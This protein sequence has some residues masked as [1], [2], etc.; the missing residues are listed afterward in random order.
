MAS[1]MIT[2]DTG[3]NTQ[4]KRKRV[5]TVYDV[6]PVMAPEGYV[7][8]FAE[9]LESADQLKNSLEDHYRS[10]SVTLNLDWDEM[11]PDRHISVSFI[12]KPDYLFDFAVTARDV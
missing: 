9:T 1:Q 7:S 11:E 5:K 10:H 2:E 12:C 4:L 8:W 6:A 3:F